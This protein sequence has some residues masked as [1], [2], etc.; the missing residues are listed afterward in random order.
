MKARS[1]LL[2]VMIVFL[3]TQCDKNKG[4]AAG[5][6]LDHI[7]RNSQ[8]YAEYSYSQSFGQKKIAYILFH[9]DHGHT[10][11]ISFG[12]QNDTITTIRTYWDGDLQNRYALTYSG[13]LPLKCTIYDGEGTQEGYINFSR[14]NGKVSAMEYDLGDGMGMKKLTFTYNGNNIAQM[15][16]YS[17]NADNQWVL[18]RKYTFEYDSQRNP[19]AL[20]SIPAYMTDPIEIARR[21]CSN[22]VIAMHVYD[23]YNHVNLG[24]FHY[25]YTYYDNGMVKTMVE[26]A[27]NVSYTLYYQK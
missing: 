9:E 22:N 17:R 1:L 7:E 4:N 5:E 10:A 20:L 16:W 26:S 6:L 19:Y 13:G 3:G 14:S 8:L 12:Y 27:G 21:A 23:E 11:K 25:T 24:T 15:D 2:I 18:M